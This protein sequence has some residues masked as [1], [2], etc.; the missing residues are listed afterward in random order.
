MKFEDIKV[1]DT[2]IYDSMH[3]RIINYILDISDNQ[4][5][6]KAIP[7]MNKNNI[8]INDVYIDTYIHWVNAGYIKFITPEE[9][10]EIL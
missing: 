1:G 3:E 10:F 4:I 2:L 9:K 7:I 5:K 8:T 6:Y